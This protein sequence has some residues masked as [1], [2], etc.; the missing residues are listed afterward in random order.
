MDV[1]F[2]GTDGVRGLWVSTRD[3]VSRCDSPVLRRASSANGVPSSFGRP[4]R[5]LL[6]GYMSRLRWKAG[7]VASGVNGS[8]SPVAHTR[9]RISQPQVRGH[10][11]CDQPSHNPYDD[12]GIKFFDATWQAL[13]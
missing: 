1:S 12:N 9:H 6:S 8:S 10:S 3:R 11:A 4:L 7:V 13:R 2:F 5:P